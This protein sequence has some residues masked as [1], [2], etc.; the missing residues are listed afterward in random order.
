VSRA[1]RI[2]LVDDDPGVRASLVRLLESAGR[3]VYPAADVDEARAV[4]VA[5]PPDVVVT[6]LLGPGDVP[7][8]VRAA[9]GIPVVL[10]SG[11]DPL[12]L[13]R[14]ARRLGADAA[15]AK[16]SRLGAVLAAIDAVTRP[17]TLAVA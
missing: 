4:L 6:D 8:L 5:W 7:A 9:A 17:R 15:V 13:E 11:S 14:T 1:M 2:L 16:P 10:L 12:Y 3:Q